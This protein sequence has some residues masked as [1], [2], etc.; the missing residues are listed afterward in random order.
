MKKLLAF[1]LILITLQ[2]YSQQIVPVTITSR[3]S[4]NGDI[5]TSWFLA[6]VSSTQTRKVSGA[7]IL[8]TA[9]KYQDSS[10]YA[11]FWRLYKVKDSLLLLFYTKSESDTRYIQTET[12]PVWS[13]AAINYF[14]K[15]Q[16]DARYLQTFTETDP[17]VPGNVKSIST[18]D[19][20]NW[21]SAFGWG[22]HASVGYAPLASPALT[23]VPTAPTA[24]AGTNTTQIA[25]TAFVQGAISGSTAG[26]AS[27]NGRAGTVVP[28]S[29]DYSFAQ[30]ASKPTTIGGYG[31]TDAFT[32]SAADGFY[33][34]LGHTH[35]FASLTSK[36]TTI[37][38]YGITDAFTQSAADG[39]Y[40][41]LGHTH[42]FASLT[43][44]PTTIAG[45]G[46]TD[47]FTQSAADALYSPLSHTHT[48]A[49]L[50]SKP[51]TLS[52][53]GIT[54][55]ENTANKAT[56]L[57]SPDNTKYP[58]TLAVSNAI[59]TNNNQL[60]NGSNYI[61]QASALSPSTTSIQDG[62]FGTIKLKD[63]TN[64][65]HYL[66][67]DNNEDLTANHFF[68]I[69]TGNA[70]RTLTLNGNATVSNTNTG[71]QTITLG[72]DLSGSGS[73][74]VNATIV[75]GA[76]T[77]GKMA[78]LVAN[79]II[80]NN[81][82]VGATPIALTPAQVKTLLAISESDVVNLT[83]DLASKV[84]GVS[85]ASAN[86]FAGTATS[87]TT[88][89]ITISTSINGILKGNGTSI[90]SATSGTDY[91]P[92]TSS[93]STGI[94]KSTTSTGALTIAVA[95]DFP[96]LNQNTTGTASNITGVLNATS[97]PALTGDVTTSSGSLA[98]AIG[99]NKVTSAMLRQGVAR[100]VVGVSGNASNNEADIQAGADNQFLSQKSSVLGFNEFGGQTSIVA[101]SAAINTTET[102][103]TQK[104]I[105][106]SQLIA[107]TTYRVTAYGTCT[108]TVVNA[109][110]FRLR[111]G[112][113]GTVSD[114]VVSVITPTSAASGTTV[115]FKI[116]MLVTI[117]TT[118]S[119]TGTT[120]GMGV[121]EN[122]G[123]TGVS[124]TT[125]VVGANTTTSALNTTVANTISLTYSSAA[126]TTT[127]TFQLATIEIVKM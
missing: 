83:S 56:S 52:G 67:I 72:N 65:S 36:P 4:Y 64:P 70:D 54:D 3:P 51:I 69:V 61:T 74:T 48:F 111:L 98:T 100:S 89:Q 15:T 106:A 33:S 22:N 6:D 75:S 102:I 97:F 107:G 47:A 110:N 93:L 91:A 10:V 105:A 96:T 20:S 126:T 53:Y 88:P 8:Q 77:L 32:K 112:T 123:I 118:G 35:T 39:L 90:S 49:S 21:N 84:T 11:T 99:A 71:D 120:S 50:T 68:H 104:S 57:A 45:Y 46:I 78:N 101:A 125:L 62:Y 14:T 2:G 103:I 37:A 58:T 60:T 113:A 80:G 23:G 73:S 55:G 19:I 122:N 114:P 79:S 108:S 81:T 119:G 1:L 121:L 12:D 109:S 18:I 94:L 117:R 26:V 63:V 86:G 30:I 127:S 82:G 116:E 95:G 43:S 13:A 31:I 5:N 92:G 29:G 9:V 17:T 41:A 44:K 59:P 34:P 42:T 25:T 27:F 24:T 87:T 28:V 66:T 40:S 124:A 16:S 115:P 38:G 85:V 7:T 76:V